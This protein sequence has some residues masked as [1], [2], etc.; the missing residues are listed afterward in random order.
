VVVKLRIGVLAIQGDFAAHARMLS[1]L[2]VET[3]EVRR[4]NQ[5]TGIDGLIMPGGESTTML[6]VMREEA[7]LDPIK[8][9]ARAGKTIFG[10]CA[11]AI[12]L[13]REVHNPPQESLGLM[14]IAVERNSYGRQIDSFIGQAVTTMGAHPLEAV[15]IRAPRIIR[16]GPGVEVISTIGG[17]PVMVRQG[18]LLAATFHPELTADERVHNLFIEM[19]SLM[20]ATVTG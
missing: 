13:A 9:F 1:R 8:E 15:F 3:V 5:L 19:T 12:L 6:K 10:T 7:M 18:N 14:D 17:E 4:S 20:S 16:T 2:G 11:G